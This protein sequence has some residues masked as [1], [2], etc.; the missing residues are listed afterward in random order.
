MQ[1]RN[2]EQWE[3]DLEY[4]LTE[5]EN[6]TNPMLGVVRVASR[7][8]ILGDFVRHLIGQSYFEGYT[9]GREEVREWAKNVRRNTNDDWICKLCGYEGGECECFGFNKAIDCL[10][11]FLKKKKK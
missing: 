1:K 9:K 8:K 10:L 6:G 11:D 5:W 2:K 4:I 7:K 3:R